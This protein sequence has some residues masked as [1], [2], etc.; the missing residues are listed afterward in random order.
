MNVNVQQ[1]PQISS[2]GRTQSLRTLVSSLRPDFHLIPAIILAYTCFLPRELWFE[3]GGIPFSPTRFAALLLFPVLL[4]IV[5]RQP[6]RF[7]PIDL[8]AGAFFLWFLIAAY[9]VDGYQ[10]ALDRGLSVSVDRMLI[11]LIGRVSMRS[12]EDFRKLLVIILPGAFLA[13]FFMMVE[14]VSRTH[15]LRPLVAEIFGRP[16]PDIQ[17]DFRFSFLRAVG[18]FY[19]PILA[20]LFLVALVPLSWGALKG[21][22]RIR[23]I[24]MSIGLFSLFALS[25]G[26]FLALAF[27]LGSITAL[28]LQRGLR[29]PFLALAAAA[30]V[31]GILALEFATKSG[32]LSFVIRYMALGSGSARYRTF[33]WEYGGIEVMNHPWFGIGAR[34]WIRPIWMVKESVDAYW[35]VLAMQYGLPSAILGFVLPLSTVFVLWRSGLRL[36]ISPARDM[37]NGIIIS[38]AMFMICG[39]TV[40][41]WDSA[42]TLFLLLTAIGISLSQVANER[43]GM[44]AAGWKS[45]TREH[46]YLAGQLPRARRNQ[47]SSPA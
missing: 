28:V 32:A 15:I 43:V 27:G 22:P 26:P 19:H 23:P 40:N 16:P 5:K 47:W 4:V 35:L 33:I 17:V 14:A 3:I 20:G 1:T 6:L 13:G 46:A 36:P 44:I 29:I 42:S 38:I 18:P 31:V 41:I 2:S 39:F 11:Y 10:L 9:M 34:D 30:G 25:S 24:G 45:G 7:S 21:L 12:H 8:L 37:Q